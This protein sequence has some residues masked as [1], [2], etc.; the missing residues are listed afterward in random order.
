MTSATGKQAVT[1][2]ELLLVIVIIGALAAVSIPQL[3]KTFDNFG[4][5]NFVKD[6]YYLSRYLQANAV[7][8]GKIYV[9]NIEPATGE[10]QANGK[11]YKAPKDILIFIEPADKTSIYFYPD[12]VTDKTT[13]TFENRYK[14]QVSLILKGISGDIQIQ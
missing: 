8:Q 10:F 12:A 14:K 5:E 3:K 7:N 1:F 11:L 13:I 9:L 4:L 2:I 6:M